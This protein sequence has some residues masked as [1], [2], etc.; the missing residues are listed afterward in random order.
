MPA[1]VELVEV[2]E[3]R[4][5]LLCPAPRDW[6][7]F[8]RKGA[9]GDRD[10]D[11]FDVEKADFAPILPIETGTGNRRIRQP[12]DRDV[13]EDVVAREALRLP[14]KDARDQLVA[15]C[16]VI[17]EIGCQAD[18]GIRDSVLRLRPEPHLVTVG[19]AFLIFE[20]QSLVGGLFFG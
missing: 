16:V 7:E 19:N 11:A 1:F 6:I 9:H 10:G 4:I 8:V 2:D 5:C 17:E 13:V 18:G 15:A 20:L 3:F 14:L 12:G